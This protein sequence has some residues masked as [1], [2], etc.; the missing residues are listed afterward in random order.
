MTHT[1]GLFL[2]SKLWIWIR[3]QGGPGLLLLGLADNS[4]IPMPG[5]MDV[6]TIWFAVHH[7]K[8]WYYFAFMATV[9]SLLGG[10]LTYRLARKGGKRALNSRLGPG[11]T[12]SFSNRFEHWGFWGIVIPALLPPPFPFVPFLLAAG[13][14][15]YSRK[16]FLAALAVGRGLRYTILA[17]L[18]V[19]YGRHF[20]R[21]FNKYT[22]PTLFVLLG[23]AVIAGIAGLVTYL[24]YRNQ[25]DSTDVPM[26][27]ASRQHAG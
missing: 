4:I 3:H 18:G 13:A 19:L 24:R 8:E 11:R 23:F 2:V 17:Y 27:A 1:L 12:K 21:F 14:L 6:L 9:G 20:L 15:Q 26:G 16:K 7:R 5:S 22:K 25:S 10:Y